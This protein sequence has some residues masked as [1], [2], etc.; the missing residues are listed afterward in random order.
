MAE[1]FDAF[2]EKLHDALTGEEMPGEEFAQRVMAQVRL[3]PQEQSA[4]RDRKMPKM[5]LWQIAACAAVVVLA[6]PVIRLTTMR[7]GSAAPAAAA[8]CAATEEGYMEEEPAAEEDMTDGL[9]NGEQK[10]KSGVSVNDTAN[11]EQETVVLSDPALIE[12][13]L[14]WLEEMGYANDG[15]YLLSAQEV[16][17]LNEAVPDLA[18][19]LCTVQLILE[20]AE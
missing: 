12:Q 9:A 4:P 5:K 13:V 10:M 2:E 18:L 19:P 17:A 7:A 8:D 11:M 6:I 1:T 20:A 15:G 3:M 16:A 14:A